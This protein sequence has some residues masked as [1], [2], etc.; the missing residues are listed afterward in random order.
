MT[1]SPPAFVRP[2]I[3]SPSVAGRLIAEAGSPLSWAADSAKT[4]WAGP[5]AAGGPA[6]AVAGAN[7]AGRRRPRT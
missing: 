5:T 1:S 7:G 3:I 4:G 6:A 2:P